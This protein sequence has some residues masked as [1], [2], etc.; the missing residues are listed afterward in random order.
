MKKP[1]LAFS[2]Y[3]QPRRVRNYSQEWAKFETTLGRSRFYEKFRFCH[4]SD[5]AQYLSRQCHSR[6]TPDLPSTAS[7][8]TF[9]PIRFARLSIVSISGRAVPIPGRTRAGGLNCYNLSRGRIGQNRALVYDPHNRVMFL[10][11]RTRGD[12]GN[13]ARILALRYQH[14]KAGLF[15]P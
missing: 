7:S 1:S 14:G 2:Q 12:R 5:C 13:D 9:G 11:L 4:R 10:V 8:P 15:A 3:V 6:L